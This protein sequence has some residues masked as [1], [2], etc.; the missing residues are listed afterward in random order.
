LTVA[1]G[2]ISLC[3][4]PWLLQHP[5]WWFRSY[6]P[7]FGWPPLAPFYRNLPDLPDAAPLL[8]WGIAGV[9]GCVALLPL[10][11]LRADRNDAALPA[12]GS[13]TER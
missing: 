2:A 1:L 8:E 10:L 13:V 3:T 6:H 7:L 11:L 5:N 12:E 9:W 4:L